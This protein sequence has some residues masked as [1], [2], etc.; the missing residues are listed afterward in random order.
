[1]L[2]IIFYLLNLLSLLFTVVA[3]G[4]MFYTLRKERVIGRLTPLL[5]AL[6]PLVMIPLF[7]ILSGA[8][9][10]WL[11]SIPIFL[12]GLAAG[13]VRGFTIKLYFKEGQVMGKQSLLFLLGWCIT[14]LL[15]QLLNVFGSVM[16]SSI[17]LMS[18]FLGT[19]T[20]AALSGTIFL[21]RMMLRP[22]QP[23]PT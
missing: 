18:L 16:L 17:G 5:S 15:A 21:R 19:G 7:M 9:L 3:F 1:M 14:L 4:L 11:L 12:L 13:V 8:R 2:K 10:N 22:P 20:Q 23:Q 6:L